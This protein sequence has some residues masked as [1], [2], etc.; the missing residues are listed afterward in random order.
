[1]LKIFKNS[2]L[3][4]ILIS[5]STTGFSHSK[6]VR[7]PQKLLSLAT[8]DPKTLE[9]QEKQVEKTIKEIQTKFGNPITASAK[10]YN[11]DKNILYG[12]IV[13]ES[14]GIHNKTSKQG[15]KGLMQ[16]MPATAKK[17]GCN[18][19]CLPTQN[20]DAAASY[21]KTLLDLF[22]NKTELALAAYNMGDARIRSQ[23]KKLGL[24]NNENLDSG[25]VINN[26]P[27]KVRIY[28]KKIMKIAE[29]IPPSE[30]DVKV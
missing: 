23:I 19:H 27:V 7:E 5:T 22:N 6:I 9:N 4:T 16:L 8:I 2:I 12:M 17:H 29:K 14:G 24:Q 1:M 26:L 13:V 3:A 10:K 15:A 18:K 11:I 30:L 28:V 21:F 25:L 20:I